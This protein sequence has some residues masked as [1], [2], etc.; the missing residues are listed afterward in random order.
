[1]KKYARVFALVS[2]ILAIALPMSGCG[3]SGKSNTTVGESY[4]YAQNASSADSAPSASYDTAYDYGYELSEPAESPEINAETS[5]SDPM[6]AA[7]PDNVKMIY[8]AELSLETTEFDQAASQL[9]QLVQELGGWL[10]DSSLYNYNKYREASYTFRVPAEHF[11]DFCQRAGELCTLRNIQRSGQDVS[12]SYYDNEARLTTQRTKLDRLQQLL[13]QAENM[14][15]II[16]LESAISETELAIEKLTGTLRHYDSLV[17]YSTITVQLSEVYKVTVTEEP[18]IGF[19]AK[20][21]AAFQAGTGYFVDDVQ[22]LL[23][24][25]ARNWAGWLIFLLIAA[26]VILL[27]RRRIR[28][29]RAQK[30]LPLP[31]KRSRKQTAQE[32]DG[33]NEP[34]A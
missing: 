5:T 9:S 8:T 17:G 30:G 28:R 34:K 32:M 33:Q 11:S 2:L 22:D 29:R 20:L 14:E 27:I 16:T 26:A 24:D 7:L 6:S 18:A 21:S 15:D 12:E 25:F 19:W 4:S 13:A 1:M 23:L 31:E 3:A 10:Q